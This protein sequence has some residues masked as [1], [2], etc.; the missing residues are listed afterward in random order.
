[1]Y[2]VSVRFILIS[3]TVVDT[4]ATVRYFRESPIGFNQKGIIVT[5]KNEAENW[6]WWYFVVAGVLIGAF[7]GYEIYD[8]K[9]GKAIG[10]FLLGAIC[11]AIGLFSLQAERKQ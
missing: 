7:G 2:L 10:S 8:A 5:T 1:L 3:F 4:G 9:V 11:I 6:K